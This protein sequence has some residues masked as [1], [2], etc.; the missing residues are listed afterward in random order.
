MLF[1]ID[2]AAV[3][4]QVVLLGVFNVLFYLDKRFIIL[5][6]TIVFTLTNFSLTA[7]SQYLGPSFY[8]YGFAL[9]VL[10]TTLAGFVVLNQ[11][12]MR[13]EYETFMLQR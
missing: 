4:V 10:L 5:N 2:V 12:L 8:G 7:F 13:L 1:A 6:L 11:K 3:G 9:S